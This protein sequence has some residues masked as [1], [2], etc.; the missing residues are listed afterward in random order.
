MIKM[1]HDI[2]S[3]K[4]NKKKTNK[5]LA[6]IIADIHEKD[7][8]IFSVLKNNP[9]IELRI[10]SLKIG[11]FQIGNMIIERKTTSDFI[12]SMISKR[13]ID[14]LTQM[15]Q[16]EQRILIIE[17]D[18]PSIYKTNKN[19][20]PN[21]IRGFILSILNNYKTNIIQTID[22]KDTSMYL[23]T[24]A[25]QQ[26]K[27]KTDITLHSRIPKTI[28]EQKQYILESFP[29]IGPKKAELLL[30]EFKTLNNVFNASEDHLKVFLKNK[31]KDFKD[32][33]EK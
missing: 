17:G 11:D 31:T 24:L 28:E 16:Y 3:K 13:L 21:A 33:L 1:L 6:I 29:N 12:S 14:Q 20:N 7:S 19:I 27:P 30:K 15:Q 4:E 22:Y 5:P 2:F 8:M 25:K 18:F 26:L 23:I 10:Q 9:D 32:I